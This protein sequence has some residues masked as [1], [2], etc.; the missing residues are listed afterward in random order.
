MYSLILKG[1]TMSFPVK[2]P[3]KYPFEDEGFFASSVTR[4]TL[5]KQTCVTVR[6][7]S[8]CVDVRDTKD[9]KSPTLSFTHDEWGAFI[10]GVKLGEFDIKQ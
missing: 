7:G 4:K 9:L 1:N 10:Q 6:M 8:E 5:L 2:T 3:K